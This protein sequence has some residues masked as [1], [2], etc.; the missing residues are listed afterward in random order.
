[1]AP[2]IHIVSCLLSLVV[3]VERW[4]GFPPGLGIGTHT[5]GAE[6]FT[7]GDL[8]HEVGLLLFQ[9]GG[10]SL[11]LGLLHSLLN[12]LALL[13]TLGLGFLLHG[14]GKATVVAL[15]RLAEIGIGLSLV[16]KVDGVG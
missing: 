8:V 1:M 13:G 2:A 11:V 6:S 5:V 7:L 15:Q 4:N 16:V 14:L 12:D 10:E 3:A 9:V